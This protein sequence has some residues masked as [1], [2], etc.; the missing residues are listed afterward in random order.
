[1]HKQKRRVGQ[2]G[3]EGMI[4]VMNQLNDNF[5]SATYNYYDVGGSTAIFAQLSAYGHIRSN[6]TATPYHPY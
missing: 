4:I 1:V 5:S 2:C 3:K 6:I